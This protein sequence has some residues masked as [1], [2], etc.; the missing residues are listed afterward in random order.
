MAFA[1]AVRLCPSPLTPPRRRTITTPVCTAAPPQSA[2]VRNLPPPGISG[3]LVNAIISI[4]PVWALMSAASRKIIAGYARS[5]GA[6]WDTHVKELGRRM[7]TSEREDILTK[8][9]DAGLNYPEYYIRSFHAYAE[10]NMGWKPAFEAFPAT[11]AIAYR[12]WTESG[13]EVGDMSPFE[14]VLANRAQTF[15]AA[16]KMFPEFENHLKTQQSVRIVDA[17]AGVGL[18]TLA[19]LIEVRKIVGDGVDV[20]IV[21]NDASPYMI[22][23]AQETI[24]EAGVTFRHELMEDTKFASGSQDMYCLQHV[25]HEIP[26]LRPTL[27]EALRVLRDGGMAIIIDNDPESRAISNLNPALMT[28]LKSTEPYCDLWWTCDVRAVALEVGFR[29]CESL[30]VTDRHRLY[31]LIK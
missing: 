19:A 21:G 16:M 9:T 28:L 30:M 22:A 29:E 8:V 24:D 12:T 1:N 20:E 31:V 25:V 13:N 7:P 18:S 27:R 17:G 3:R 5:G 11:V 4:P 14:L 10:G 6:D 2:P 26:D 15:A 23:V